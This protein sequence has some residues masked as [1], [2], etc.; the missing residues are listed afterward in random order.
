M[1]DHEVYIFRAGWKALEDSKCYLRK[2]GC[3]TEADIITKATA[4]GIELDRQVASDNSRYADVDAQA[5]FEFA[6]MP[7]KAIELGNSIEILQ[8]ITGSD[9]DWQKYRVGAISRRGG[10]VFLT[11]APLYGEL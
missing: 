7:A 11:L 3:T 9:D 10:M 5:Q 1:T 6:D 4:A 2:D 8:P